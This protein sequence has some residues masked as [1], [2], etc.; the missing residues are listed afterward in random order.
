MS[1]RVRGWVAVICCAGCAG[2]A[3]CGAE[4][5]ASAPLPATK[6]AVAPPVEPAS[7]AVARAATP[8]V[9]PPPPVATVPRLAVSPGA[10]TLEPG[11]PGVQFRATWTPEGA[12][13]AWRDV[14]AAS[15]WS[16]EPRTVATIDAGGYLTPLASGKA[17]VV[18][19]HDGASVRAEVIVESGGDSAARGWDFGQDIVPILTR[20]GCNVGGCHGRADGQNGFHLSLFGYDPAGDFQAVAR[21]GGARRVSR[22]DP[23]ASLIVL[24]ATG[25][26][27]HA[28]G[29]RIQMN[30]PEYATLVGWIAAGA[31]ERAGKSHGALARLDLEPAAARLIEPGP[32]QMRVLATYA[33]G[34][35]RDVTR[36]AIYRVLDDGSAKIDGRGTA[37]L[38]RRAEA[39]LV[40]RYQSKVVSARLATLINPDLKYDFKARKH[41]N[42]IDDELFKRL[43]ALKVPPSPAAPDAVFLRRV[44]LDLTGETPNPERVREYLA[45][46]DPEKRVKLVDKLLASRDFHRFWLLKFGD[47]LQISTRRLGNGSSYYMMWLEKRLNEDAPWDQVV[48]SLLTAVGEPETRDGGA[49]NYAFDGADPKVAAELTAQRFLGLRIRCAQCHD[50]PFDVWTQDDYFGMAALFAKASATANMSGRRIVKINDAGMVEHPR[51]H[52]AAEAKLLG[53]AAVRTSKGEDPRKALAEWITRPENPFFARATVNWVWAQMFG[54]GIVDPPD[55]LS[56]SNPAVHPELLDALARH[57]V[58][59]HFDLRD[60]IRTIATSEAYALS[61]ATVPGNERDTR[62][63]SHQ[64]PRPLTSHQIV[65]ALAQATDVENRFQNRPRGTRALDIV[66]PATP[67]AILDVFGR[68]SRDVGCASVATPQLSLRQ[69]LLLIGGDV[70]QNKVA[71][72]RGYLANL[73]ALDPQPEEIVENLYLRTLCRPPTPEETSRW[74]AELKQAGSLSDAAEDLFWALLNSREFTFNH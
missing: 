57:F 42:F 19:R 13:A 69:S 73:L 7:A 67:S 16:V 61:S 62:F 59:H 58:A 33:D 45:D 43:E 53:G 64:W 6:A 10:S 5:P 26:T 29:P 65:D 30:T 49:A 41:A 56:R 18:A 51:T 23:E 3:G 4:Q 39:D 1:G 55:D 11:D 47:L 54:K 8:E 38:S 71:H 22:F 35:V 44:A 17:T 21:D 52:Q 37:A 25:Q 14:T 15:R 34:H 50:H 48:R 72:P 24:K 31:P 9:A 68:C 40:V 2:W 70:V 27:P 66:D 46:K 32:V 20:A 63:F 60:L 28:G 36:M 74:S 12:D